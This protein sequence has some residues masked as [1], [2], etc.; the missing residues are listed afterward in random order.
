VND[1]WGDVG[2]SNYNSL[3]ITSVKR[4]SGGLTFNFNYTYAKAFD[5]TGSNM[6][7]VQSFTQRSAYNWKIEKARSQLSP[8]TVNFISVYDAQTA[9]R[10]LIS[11]IPRQAYTAGNRN[12]ER[13]PQLSC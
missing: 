10:R 13:V 6:V 9:R 7:T 5:D 11:P 8:H 4:L 2:N 12:H 3:Q 1:V